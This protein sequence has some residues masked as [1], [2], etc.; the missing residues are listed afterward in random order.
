MSFTGISCNSHATS[1]FGCGLDSGSATPPGENISAGGGADGHGGIDN[2]GDA[3]QPDG[4]V[5]HD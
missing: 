5:E 1:V 4:D 2:I 3:P